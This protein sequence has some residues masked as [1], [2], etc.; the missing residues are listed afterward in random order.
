MC[1]RFKSVCLNVLLVLFQIKNRNLV[2][3][4]PHRHTYSQCLFRPQLLL[5]MPMGTAG[6]IF[7]SAHFLGDLSHL[8]LPGILA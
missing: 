8:E 2:Y 5:S 6:F 3:I 7:R 4:L 1:S